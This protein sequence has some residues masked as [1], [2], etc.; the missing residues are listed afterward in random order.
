MFPESIST[1][2]EN[3]TTEIYNIISDNEKIRKTPNYSYDT[4]KFVLKNGNTE[5]ID[6]YSNV[7]NWIIKFIRT[8]IDIYE[9]YQGTGFGTSLYKIK[10]YKKIDGLQFAQIK[11]EIEEG[12][13]L[14][15]N[16]LEVSDID[17]YKEEKNVVV[18][19]KVKLQDGY[20][21]EEK[22]EAYTVL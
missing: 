16:I 21:L 7:R 18:E 5:L 20:I 12:F 8:P 2:E 13:K 17:I 22:I 10:G 11:K 6:D 9:I 14:N 15:P 3:S 1:T 4:M 19:L